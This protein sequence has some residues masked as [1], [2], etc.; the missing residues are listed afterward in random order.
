VMAEGSHAEEVPEAAAV[1]AADRK[2]NRS[3]FDFVL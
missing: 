3:I 2:D 1:L